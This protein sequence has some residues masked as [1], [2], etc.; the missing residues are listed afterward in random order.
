[1]ALVSAPE[2]EAFE[3]RLDESV[4]TGHA[5]DL[6]VIGYGEIT[7]G[8]KLSTRHG[9][10][11]CK[12][13]V[14]FSSREAAKRYAVLIASYVEQL[15]ACGI[16]VVET[17]TAI[18]ERPEGHVLY[19]IQPLLAAGTLG[20]DFLRGK[21]AK[22][23]TPCVRRIFEQIQASVTPLLAP[24]GQ[25]SN[26]A[27]EGDRLRYLD[28]GTPFLRDEQGKQLVDFTE[29]TRALPA[30]LRVIVNRFLLRGILDAYHSSRGQAV[31]FLGNLIKEGLGDIFPPL[32]PIANEVFGLTPGITEQEVRAHYKS[33]AQTWALMQ[34]ARRADRWFYQRIL[35]KPYP[36][37]LPPRID[38]YG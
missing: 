25:L 16:D 30:P 26:W 13:L 31:D 21:S 38:R 5:G 28:V 2:I 36:Y 9:D 12:R 24:D 22:E 11:A 19:C 37:L 7:I 33:D 10:F 18:L 8:V 20:P 1:M 27:F 15:G 32:L 3:Q 6:D 35:R 14:P 17:E 34:A 23:A 29:Q 4:R